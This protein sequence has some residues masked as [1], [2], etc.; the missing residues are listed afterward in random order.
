MWFLTCASRSVQLPLSYCC[1]LLSPL[2]QPLWLLQPCRPQAP[3]VSGVAS[4]AEGCDVYTKKKW[5]ELSV[6]PEQPLPCPWHSS[7]GLL[8]LL[9]LLEVEL[10]PV[11]TLRGQRNMQEAREQGTQKDSRSRRLEGLLPTC[12]TPPTCTFSVSIYLLLS[13]LRHRVQKCICTSG[14]PVLILSFVRSGRI[15]CRKEIFCH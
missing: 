4:G 12:T 2:Q 11:V 1:L 14:C 3:R 7:L 15:Q 6:C 9:L 13:L 10:P 8:L 5:W